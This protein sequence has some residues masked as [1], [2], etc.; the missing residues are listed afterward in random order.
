MCLTQHGYMIHQIKKLDI[1]SLEKDHDAVHHYIR[2]LDKQ[3]LIRWEERK[4][5]GPAAPSTQVSSYTVPET[6]VVYDV[7]KHSDKRYDISVDGQMHYAMEHVL[8]T[9][10]QDVLADYLKHITVPLKYV[11]GILPTIGTDDSGLWHRD[12]YE[13]FETLHSSKLPPWYLVC[14]LCLNEENDAPTILI[15][16]S[17]HDPRSVDAIASSAD[18]TMLCIRPK[19]GQMLIMDGRLVH[20]G[21]AGVEQTAVRKMLY[22]TISPSWYDDPIYTSTRV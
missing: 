22:T 1:A 16:S 3:Q 2:S 5:H 10:L 12:T 14:L 7:A 6:G 17:H 4:K 11:S 19:I 18:T 13:L 15:P 21:G 8:T 20:R 9:E